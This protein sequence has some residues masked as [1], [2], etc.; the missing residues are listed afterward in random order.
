MNPL[1]CPVWMYDLNCERD[2]QEGCSADDQWVV[3][4]EGAIH[5]GCKIYMGTEICTVPSERYM[6]GAALFNDSTLL[7]YGTWVH[8]RARERNVEVYPQKPTERC[9]VVW[10][11][12]V[13]CDVM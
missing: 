12:V 11:G 1:H 13:L 6:H 7:V 8:R 4:H 3:L 9:D 10:C 5:G 2:W